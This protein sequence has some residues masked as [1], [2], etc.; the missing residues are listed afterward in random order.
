MVN[1]QKGH[2]VGMIHLLPLPGTLG[3][4]GSFDQ[5][6]ERAVNDSYVL[7]KTGFD[8]LL[9]QNFGDSPF[10]VKVDMSTVAHMSVVCQ[11]IHRRVNIPTGVCLLRNDGPASIAVAAATGCSF[12]RIKCH[13]GTMVWPEGLINSE[14]SETLAVRQRLGADILIMADISEPHA[15]NLYVDDIAEVARAN[16]GFGK[17]DVLL[18]TAETL[19]NALDLAEK[20]RIKTPSVKLFLGGGSRP[21]TV[22]KILSVFDGIVVG[23]GVKISNSPEAPVDENLAASF[24]DNV[25]ES[26][27]RFTLEQ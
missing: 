16:V 23:K 1:I 21:E 17:A 25:R 4:R 18:I 12:V 26:T 22:K 3:Y 6:V 11:E 2:V 15:R 13:A 8:S 20:V 19:D 27:R 5:V 7:E 14:A 10:K 9:I 24:I